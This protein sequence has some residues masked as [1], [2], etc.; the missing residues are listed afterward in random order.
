VLVAFAPRSIRPLTLLLVAWSIGV[1]VVATVTRP[2]AQELYEDP[3]VQLWIPRL[4]AGDLADTLAWRRWGFA[5]FE[6]L[7]LLAIGIVVA[8]AGGLATMSRDRASR[9]VVRLSAVALAVLIVACA[10]PVPAPAS[11]W[12]PSAPDP[13]SPPALAIAA[14]GAYRDT[15]GGDDRMIIW[16]QLVN[17]GGTVADTRIEYRVAPLDGGDG[18]SAW[19]GDIAW[20]PGERKTSSLPWTVEP[21]VDPAG[22]RYQVLVVDDAT[23]ETLAASEPRP[24]AVR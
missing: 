18:P 11:V 24:F 1:M 15:G 6:P 13:S 19:Y 17:G 2:N 22:Y 4:L 5:G 16:A 12:L 10:L 20:T 21:G 8:V 9:V 23:G 14:S 7:V 3:L